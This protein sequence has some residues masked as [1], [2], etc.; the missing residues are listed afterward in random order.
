M[1]EEGY[2][3]LGK[4]LAFYAKWDAIPNGT[5]LD[6]GNKAVFG[7]IKIIKGRSEIVFPDGTREPIYADTY[8][9]FD[10]NVEH[11]YMAMTRWNWTWFDSVRDQERFEEYAKRALALM[12]K[13]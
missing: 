6:I 7:G 1:W 2:A 4:A 5:A 12:E 8:V 13:K 9:E 3:M 10:D 11:M